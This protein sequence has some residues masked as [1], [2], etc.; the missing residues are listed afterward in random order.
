MNAPITYGW[1]P[2]DPVTGRLVI[3]GCSRRKRAT[4]VPVPALELYEGGCVP[5]LRTRIGAHPQHRARVRVLS[6]EH[7]LLTADTPVLPYERPLDE[8]RIGELRPQVTATL[9]AEAIRDG[10]PRHLLLVAEPRY[11]SLLADL[12]RQAT[13]LAR[14]RRRPRRLGMAMTQRTRRPNRRPATRSYDPRHVVPK[15]RR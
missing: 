6:G 15:E 4:D 10:M 1:A 9:L 11:L 14:G 13:L 8:H 3:V 5:E 12:F 2:D 7:G